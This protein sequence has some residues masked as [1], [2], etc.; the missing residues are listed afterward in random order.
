MT[1]VDTRTFGKEMSI[2][3]HSKWVERMEEVKEV[4]LEKWFQVP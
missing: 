4:G 3:I 2:Q 1:S